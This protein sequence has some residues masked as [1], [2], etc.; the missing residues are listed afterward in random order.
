MYSILFRTVILYAFIT[1]VIHGM[2]KR[3]VGEIE[4]SDFVTTILLSQI[5]S[6]PIE[7]PSIP[8]FHVFFP[9]LII[10]SLEIMV[11]FLKGRFNP[12]KRLFEGKPTFLMK[13]GVIDQRELLRVRLTIEELLS[14]VRRQGFRDIG[15]IHFAVLEE[16]GQFSMIPK[17]SAEPPSAEDLGLTL[18]E[19]GCALP[20]VCDGVID[21]DNL[22]RMGRDEGWLTAELTAHGLSADEVFLM[23]L[24]DA[25]GVRITRKE[26]AA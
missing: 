17:R 8:L 6:L 20:L 1:I 10:V 19:C 5:I 14:E 21:R 7:D 9:V 15:E 23:T 22:R 3:Q 11:T 2:G 12:L 13:R 26:G 16:N 25:G 4:M 24:D 18:T